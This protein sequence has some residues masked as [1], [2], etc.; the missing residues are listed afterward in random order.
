MTKEQ[1]DNLLVRAA[2]L[3]TE[4]ASDHEGDYPAVKAVVDLVLKEAQAGSDEKSA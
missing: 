1:Y 2:V 4:K 3:Y